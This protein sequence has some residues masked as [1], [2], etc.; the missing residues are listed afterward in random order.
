MRMNTGNTKLVLVDEPSSAMDPKAEY[1]LFRNLREARA[2]KT[3]ICVT[4]R[5]GHL[6][7][8]ADL[9]LCLKDGHLVE[10]G[11]HT[12]LMK[13]NG[14]YK[15]MYNL[16]AHGFTDEPQVNGQSSAVPEL[17]VPTI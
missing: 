9:I 13:K 8:H 6:T 15:E 14:E 1:E 11:T 10:Q 4:H 2:G 12:E 16:Q 5:F 17:S 3:M 7:K